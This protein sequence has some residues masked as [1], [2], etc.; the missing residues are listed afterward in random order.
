MAGYEMDDVTIVGGGPAGC[1]LGENLAKKGF[2]VTILEEHPEIGQPMCCAGILG[3]ERL[4]EI[5]LNSEDWC[6]TKLRGGIFHSPSG[7]SVELTRDQIEAHVIDRAKF[8]RSLA[9]KAVRAGAK[10]KLRSRCK[11]I[12]RHDAGVSLKVKTP[13][14]IENLKSQIAVGADGTNSLVARNCGLLKNFSPKACAQAEI[15]GKIETHK[16]NVYLG[17]DLSRSFFGWVVPSGEVYRVGI[18]DKKGNPLRKL[19]KLIER[20]NLLPQNP[21]K[22]IVRFTTGLIPEPS[23]RKIY[24]DR[25]IL[26]GDAAG[27]VKPLT[28]GGLYLGLSCTKIASKIA[29][30]ALEDE[31]SEENLEEYENAVQEK[32]GQEFRLG[33]RARKML[34]KMSDDDLSEFLELMTLPKIRELIL[35]HAA[36]DRHSDLFKALIKEGPSLIEAVGARNLMKYVN[37]FTDI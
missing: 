28:G 14:G 32:F 16:A 29:T 24:G 37:W 31:P 19:I 12:S 22:K 2:E 25:V 35:E 11:E 34:E 26:V 30:K 33:N 7:D 23:G 9:E 5:G 10:I 6:L 27:H 36:F 13:G 1:F 18:G 15:A 21:G 20:A 8:D 17:N 4:K 3:T